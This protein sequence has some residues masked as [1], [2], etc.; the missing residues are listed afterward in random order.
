MPR[1]RRRRPNWPYRFAWLGVWLALFAYA[2]L[3]TVTH[4]MSMGRRSYGIDWQLSLVA[5]LFDT[6]VAV[7][8]FVVGACIGSFLNVVAYRLPLSRNIGGHSACP[9]CNTPIDGVDNVPVL[10]WIKLRGRCRSCRLPI[11]AQYPLVEL[12]VALVFLLVYLTEFA[13]GGANLPSLGSQASQGGILRV[14]VTPL[15]IL[16]LFTYLFLLSSLIAAALIAVKRRRVPLKLYAWGVA[17]LVC[18]ALLTPALLIV[19]WRAVTTLG[20]LEARLDAIATLTAGAVAAIAVARLL[21]PVAYRGFDPSL[22]SSDGHSAGARQFIGAMA[23]AGASVGWQ[24]CVP[25][26]WCVVLCGLVGVSLVRFAARLS[27]TISTRLPLVAVGDLSV[28]VWLGLL[29]LRAQWAWL[30]SCQWLPEAI[31]EVLRHVAGAILLAPVVWLLVQLSGSAQPPGTV[32]P[33]TST[34]DEARALAEEEEDELTTPE[35]ASSEDFLT[36]PD[37]PKED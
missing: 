4:A 11:S 2:A 6:T 22:M 1:K 27:S 9:Y 8:F 23:V 14:S 34:S 13:T 17:P 19:P 36:E 12:S 29:V 35:L 33:S 28:W 16:R 37:R 10:A 18:G 15:T 24:S 30:G 20:P 3:Q 7:F 26:A 5:S 21:A 31:P 25:L 32:A